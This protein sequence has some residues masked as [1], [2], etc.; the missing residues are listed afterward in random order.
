MKTLIELE[1]KLHNSTD[2]Q[3]SDFLREVLHE[4]F[5]EFGRSGFSTDKPDTLASLA[6]ETAKTIYAEN[7]HCSPLSD[8]TVLM[9]YTSF[10]QQGGKKTKLTN[11]SSIW[12]KNSANQWQLRFHQGTPVD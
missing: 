2:R 11:R 10:E 1:Q 8:N 4:D 9:T 6:N 3:N 12:L 7:F 5:F